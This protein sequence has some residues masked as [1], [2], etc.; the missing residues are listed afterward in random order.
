MNINYFLEPID[1]YSDN[2]VFIKTSFRESIKILFR[3][4]LIK[5]FSY[6]PFKV[7][8]IC[9]HKNHIEDSEKNALNIIEKRKMYYQECRKKRKENGVRIAPIQKTIIKTKERHDKTRTFFNYPSKKESR[10]LY[11]IKNKDKLKE[12]YIIRRNSGVLKK[13]DI[14]DIGDKQKWTCFYCMRKIN[15]K[16]S[17]DHYIPI[18]LG[19]LTTKDNI[20]L[21]CLS[22]NKSKGKK[23]PLEFYNY[24]LKYGIKGY[25]YEKSLFFKKI[26]S[27]H[28]NIK[29]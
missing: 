2:D 16:F 3:K 22:C 29:K 27:E 18:K 12:S 26:K 21:C 7:K 8:F 13:W 5:T 6:N 10:L 9:E 23:T 1:V 17:K 15:S 4:K 14:L 19:G 28:K 11:Q 24:I 25:I 20:V